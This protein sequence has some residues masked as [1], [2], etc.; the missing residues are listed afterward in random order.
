M[1]GV[2]IAGRGDI[3]QEGSMADAKTKT[4]TLLV[5]GMTCGHCVMAT[6][7]SLASV[8]GVS[9]VAVTLDPPRAVVTYAPATTGVERLEAA[10]R[11][12]G[13]EASAAPGAGG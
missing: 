10:V 11:D 5:R 3:D 13:Y 9:E 12:A 6:R 1:D 7:K 4:V 8:P 2:L